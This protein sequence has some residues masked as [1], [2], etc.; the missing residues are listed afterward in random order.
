MIKVNI[1]YETQAEYRDVRR[2]FLTLLP[3][4]AKRKAARKKGRY[5]HVYVSYELPE[6][7]DALQDA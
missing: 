6:K 5:H 2:R 7:T 4:G 3:E 1:S